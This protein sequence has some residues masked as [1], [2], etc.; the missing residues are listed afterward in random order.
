MRRQ[1]TR[2]TSKDLLYS[3]GQHGLISRQQ[4]RREGSLPDWL[5]ME[6]NAVLIHN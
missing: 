6:R 3:R 2:V 5:L 4:P 1:W